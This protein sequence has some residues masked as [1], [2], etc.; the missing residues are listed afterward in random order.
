MTRRSFMPLACVLVWLG[1]DQLHAAVD[2]S[3]SRPVG[4][5]AAT[6][7]RANAEP[8]DLPGDAPGDL[9]IHFHGA[10]DTIRQAVERAGIRATVVVVNQ[11]GLSAAYALPFREDPDVFASLL[12]LA[13]Q[14]R[15]HSADSSRPRWRHITLSCFSAG[16]GA[17]REILKD[18]A[19]LGRVDTIVAADSIYAGLED[20]AAEPGGRRVESR[21]MAEFLAFAEA[22]TRG[23]TVFVVTHSAQPTPYAS[24]TETAD[25]LLAG[26]GLAREVIDPAADEE[27]PLVSRVRRGGL[28]V[29]GFA[30]GSGPAH[31]FHLRSIDR[32]WE[33]ARRRE[34][35]PSPDDDR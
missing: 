21:D 18:P 8:H 9:L 10:V 33:V 19:A 22:A 2:V 5:G 23:E 26:V 12:E 32:W 24:T 35:A 7:L 11:P 15:N 17:V 29:M 34:Q 4:K 3:A 27:F 1:G 28:V 31:L 16:Y 25:Y 30:G 13:G 14:P 20:T 6:V